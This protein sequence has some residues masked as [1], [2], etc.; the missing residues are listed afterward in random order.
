L[1]LLG[2]GQ[3]CQAL[4][5]PMAIPLLVCSIN[6]VEVTRKMSVIE[7]WKKKKMK[8]QFVISFAW[9][10]RRNYGRGVATRFG[11]QTLSYLDQL[12][13]ISYQ[14]QCHLHSY[15]HIWH[16]AMPSWNSNIGHAWWSVNSECDCTGGL[17]WHSTRCVESK[18]PLCLIRH[19]A[20]KMHRW[21]VSF[22]PWSL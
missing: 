17:S 10:N 4:H 19:K 11:P 18:L 5:R 9:T 12:T 13:V 6:L 14:T 8:A 7:N 21:V 3:C 15:I 1:S 2:D 20:L 22:T 16:P